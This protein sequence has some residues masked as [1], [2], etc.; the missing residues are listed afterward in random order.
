MM[1]EAGFREIFVIVFV[2]VLCQVDSPN[3]WSVGHTST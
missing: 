2:I 3:P 1:F